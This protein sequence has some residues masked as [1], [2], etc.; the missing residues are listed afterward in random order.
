M[1]KFKTEDLFGGEDPGDPVSYSVYPRQDG[2]QVNPQHISTALSQ[3]LFR[4]MVEY[5]RT[6]IQQRQWRTH[7]TMSAL[8]QEGGSMSVVDRIMI[9][10]Q[11]IVYHR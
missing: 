5:W 10:Q 7:L 1:F 8:H 3:D 6:C 11:N 4:N 2:T 9:K